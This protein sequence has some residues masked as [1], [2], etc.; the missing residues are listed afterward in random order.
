MDTLEN[1]VQTYEKLEK[2]KDVIL[3]YRSDYE[4][5]INECIRCHD[6]NSFEKILNEFF[7]LDKQYDHSLITTELLRLDFIKDALLKE[8]S[9]GFR[10]FWEDVDNVNDL[11]SNYNKTIFMLRRL[12]FDL[13][14]VYKRESFDHLIKVTPFIL[15]TIYEDISSPVFMKDYVFISLAME[16]LKLKS[17]RFSINYLRLV[18][19][20]NDEIN[21]LISQLQS[22]TSSSGDENE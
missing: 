7:D 11:I 14:E 8:C 2:N 9:N 16:H 21:K 15:Q 18:Y 6:L 12:T 19:H 1:L 22:L 10:L 20:K 17:Y 13:P 4:T 5:S 3:K